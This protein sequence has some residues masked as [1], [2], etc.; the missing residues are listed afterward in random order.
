M[1]SLQQNSNTH[2]SSPTTTRFY[3]WRGYERDDYLQPRASRPLYQIVALPMD[4]FTV[5]YDRLF[6]HGI[7]TLDSSLHSNINLI[8]LTYLVV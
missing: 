8:M 6:G 3:R 2:T 7:K 5:S 1:K 4:W